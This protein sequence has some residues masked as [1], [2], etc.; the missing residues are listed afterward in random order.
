MYERLVVHAIQNGR[1]ENFSSRYRIYTSKAERDK[2]F[3]LM[4]KQGHIAVEHMTPVTLTITAE[5][6]EQLTFDI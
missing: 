3:D 1:F 5:S 6:T 2:T 4:K